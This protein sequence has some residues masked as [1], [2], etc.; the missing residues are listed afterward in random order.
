MS[1]IAELKL[2]PQNTDHPG[3]ACDLVLVAEDDLM[4]RRILQTWLESW[5]Y[6]VMIAIDGGQA[7]ELLQG[8]NAPHLLILDWMM[9]KMNGVELCRLIRERNHSPYQYIL[10]VTAKDGTTDLVAGLEAGAD[11]YLSKP[12]NKNELRARLRTGRRILTLQAEQMKA[13]EKLQFQATHDGLTGVWNRNAILDILSHEF[14]RSGRGRGSMGIVIL[15][16][17]HFKKVNDSYGHPAGDLVLKEAVR[18]IQEALRAYDSVGRYG[19]EEFLIVLPDCNQNQV[20]RCAE[21]VRLR[22]AADPVCFNGIQIPVTASLG[23]AVT[24]LLPHTVKEALESA[25]SALYR[26]KDSGRN[27]VVLTLVA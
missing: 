26:A 17:D 10:L 24:S 9:P 22:I 14:E 4:F 27:R 5:G 21:R 15:D 7:W 19:G 2:I 13:H 1:E 23:V 11:D 18:R 12:F 8:E 3:E 20:E 25:D 6:Q 16:L